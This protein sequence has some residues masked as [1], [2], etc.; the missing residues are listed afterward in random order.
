MSKSNKS[1]FETFIREIFP[2]WNLKYQKITS[3]N[4]NNFQFMF[5]L[6]PVNWLI[7]MFKL[8]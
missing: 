3:K 1:L 8:A 5:D 2:H 6:I 7:F 4:K